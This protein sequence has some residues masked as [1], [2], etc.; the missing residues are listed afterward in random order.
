MTI[1]KIDTGRVEIAGDG[2]T[3]RA[4]LNFAFVDQS[5]LQVIHT[6]ASGID[7]RW[8]FRQVPGSWYFSGGNFDVGTVFFSPGDLRP[9][10]HLT[11]TLI[12][13]F[14]QPY[15]FD[16]GEIDPTVIER[17]LDRTAINMQSLAGRA[18]VE[19]GG[20]FDLKGRRLINALEAAKNSDLATLQ[21]VLEIASLPG[22]QG[23]KG[24]QGDSGPQ[25]PIGA[26]GPQGPTGGVGPQGAKGFQGDQGPVG[27]VGPQGPQGLLGPT[28]AQGPT[29][30][31]GPQ[32]SQG[33]E[34]PIG[35]SYEPDQVGITSDRSN[36][37]AE[38]RG[39]SFL[40]SEAGVLYWKLS[41]EVA[42]WSDGS[43]FG[44]GDTGLQGSQGPQGV[45][46]ATGPIGPEG[47]QGIQ[48]P[49][50]VVGP[51]GDQ[52]DIGPQGPTGPTGPQGIQGAS[53]A[54]GAQGPR[55]S[56]GLN[57]RGAWG[58]G[59]AYAV[60]DV[61]NY[62]GTAYVAIAPGT[63]KNPSTQ[64][65][66][67]GVLA[68]KGATGAQGATGARGP[69]GATGPKGATG[70]KGATGAKGNTGNTGPAGS[71]DVWTGTSNATESYPIG[72]LVYCTLT[73]EL[74]LN[75]SRTIGRDG[76]RGSII[77]DHSYTITFAGTWRSRGM[78]E[79]SSGTAVM[80]RVA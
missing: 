13:D 60:D 63:N 73:S 61:A 79:W 29:G 65:A 78:S 3:G 18:L 66:Y 75:G 4:D 45:E 53:G 58:S 5:N 74:G 52:G 48:G 17:A 56:K 41:N 40:D 22:A 46:G 59:N 42:A 37:D 12:S 21:Q 80:Q 14:D 23:A 33:P 69:T 44:R 1:G 28:G 6:D 76:Q 57:Y 15:N 77:R 16:G 62:N 68:E 25:G 2:V 38:P 54:T 26:Q 30:L 47:P 50:G 64:N 43:T 32:G 9:G 11:V 19:E 70:T 8:I 10:E 31:T 71:F 49:Q 7:T 72:H 24:P 39:F 20:S 51:R 35:K 55:G 27:I 67:W 36:Y 34:G